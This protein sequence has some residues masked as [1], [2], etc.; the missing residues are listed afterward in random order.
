MNSFMSKRNALT[1]KRFPSFLSSLRE[2]K[3]REREKGRR[4][5]FFS[6]NSS[7]AVS[8][9]SKHFSFHNKKS[10]CQIDPDLNN[11]GK[12][13]GAGGLKAAAAGGR[14]RMKATSNGTDL[15]NV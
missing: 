7:V 10:I 12:E 8:V 14:Q 2:I 13:L 1:P 4:K 6:F 15:K 9:A 11:F 3:E 5:L